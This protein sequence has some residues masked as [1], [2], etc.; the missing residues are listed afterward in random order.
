MW[1]YSLGI[2]LRR[3]I[4]SVSASNSQRRNQRGT[5]SMAKSE[6][7]ATAVGAQPTSNNNVPA[8]TMATAKREANGNFGGAATDNENI[9]MIYNN[10]VDD[11]NATNCDSDSGNG[12]GKTFKNLTSL[13]YVI[14]TMC[15]PNIHYRASLMYLLDVSTTIFQLNSLF[16]AWRPS[17]FRVP[18]QNSRFLPFQLFCVPEMPN[19]IHT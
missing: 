5:R 19:L 2:T 8:V 7:E 3:T 10:S 15:E 6:S 17:P 13:E 12:S 1:I 16:L 14:R 11:G 18:A 4:Q 9:K